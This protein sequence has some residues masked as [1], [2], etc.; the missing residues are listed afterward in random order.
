VAKQ[1]WRD[2]FPAFKVVNG[3]RAVQIIDRPL[4]IDTHASVRPKRGP[5]R[6]MMPCFE[7]KWLEEEG[8][9]AVVENAWSL[10]TNI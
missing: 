7:V 3:A 8:C 4:I 10:A 2:C 9:K 1:T 5:A 6:G